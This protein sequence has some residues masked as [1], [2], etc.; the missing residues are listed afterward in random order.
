MEEFV[1]QA[2]AS[3]VDTTILTTIDHNAASGI[4]RISREVLADVIILGWPQRSS[5][6]D[7]LIGEKIDN[8]LNNTNKTTFICHIEKPLVLHKRIVIAAP[9]LAE[10]EEGFELWLT[11]VAKLAQEL[12]V[13]IILFCN[14]STKRAA[15]KLFKTAKLTASLTIE[16]FTDWEEFFIISRHIKD[17]DLIVLACARSGATSYMSVLEHLPT[18][19][20]KRFKTHTRLIIYP[21]QYGDNISIG[22]YNDITM[23]PLNKG[24]GAVQKFGK[25]I[26]HIFKKKDEEL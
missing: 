5:F 13:P 15:E 6:F 1:K 9:P 7:K 14:N 10:H 20:G 26:G 19:I 12:S 25:G 16:H 3:E 4:A 2:S 24:I 17:D 21:Q 23:E 18:K 11:K 22:Q 8:I